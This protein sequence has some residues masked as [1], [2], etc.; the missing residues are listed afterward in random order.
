MGVTRRRCWENDWI[1]E[2]DIRRD[3]YLNKEFE[4]LGY[5]FRGRR[6]K[7]R[8]RNSF[9]VSFT[10]AVSRTAQIKTLIAWIMR[11]YRRYEGHKTKASNFLKSILERQPTLFAHWKMGMVGGL[12]NGSGVS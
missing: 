7:C 1:V 10:S 12:P 4:F 9:F 2:Y 8:E 3:E 11:K 5:S 6:V